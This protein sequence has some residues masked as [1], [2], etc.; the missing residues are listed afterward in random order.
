MTGGI[1]E[2]L[3]AN[4]S[5]AYPFVE[6]SDF[7]TE[8]GYEVPAWCLLDVFVSN[9]AIGSG[10]NLYELVEMV[11]K[12]ADSGEDDRDIELV[13]SGTD[14]STFSTFAAWRKG[15]EFAYIRQTAFLNANPGIPE[16]CTMVRAV[17]GAAGLEHPFD[18]PVG[19]HRLVNAPALLQ[20]RQAA[21][22]GGLG[23]YRLQAGESVSGEIHLADGSNCTLRIR[24]GQ[25]VMSVGRGLGT[26]FV[27]TL[28]DDYD[29]EGRN[30]GA[31][32]MVN[33]QRSDTNGNITVAGGEGITI[34]AG[35][36]GNVPGIVVRADKTV[37]NIARPLG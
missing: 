17:G 4:A 31:L 2:W 23:L 37:D 9:S 18:V 28:P 36:S 27:C 25:V 21:V 16:L 15:K 24:N 12:E 3:D 11:V 13:F 5:R 7:R 35:S 34:S 30:R 26:G 29:D 10:R 22:P 6:N 32:L 19:T 14:G 8:S 33:G 20:S 1:V